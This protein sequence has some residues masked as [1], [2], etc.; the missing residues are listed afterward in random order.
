[1]MIGRKWLMKASLSRHQEGECQ[2]ENLCPLVFLKQ[3]MQIRERWTH[4]AWPRVGEL[5]LERC[6]SPRGGDRGGYNGHGDHT[7]HRGGWCE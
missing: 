3:N 6:E 1:M 7:K 5:P 4:C 2:W